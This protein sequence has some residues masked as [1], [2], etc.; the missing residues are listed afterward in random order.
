MN[1]A[2]ECLLTTRSSLDAHQRKQ[3][4]DFQVALCQNQDVATETI[5]EPKA[6]CTVTV[7]EAESHCVAEIRKVESYSMAQACSIQQS[8]SEGMQHLKMDALE[9]E[10][11]DCLS[12]LSACGVHCRPVPQMPLGYSCT[13]SICSQGTCLWPLSCPLPIRHLLLGRNLLLCLP[14]W[15]PHPPQ[16]LN[17][18]IY[19]I[20]CLLQPCCSRD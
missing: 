6:H 1:R 3:V 17:D 12:F 14:Q 18:P 8:H 11:R 15:H 10:G 4:S 13:L 7:K 16:G 5:R 9:E 20:R 2:M 19:L